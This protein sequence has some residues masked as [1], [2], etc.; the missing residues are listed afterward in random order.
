ML[1]NNIQKQINLADNE[2]FICLKLLFENGYIK[3]LDR[4][5]PYRDYIML[6][7]K[8]IKLANYLC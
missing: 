7:K 6:T 1:T 2:F 4:S 3:E 5:K 8:G